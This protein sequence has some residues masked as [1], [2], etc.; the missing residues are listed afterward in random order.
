MLRALE[1]YGLRNWAMVAAD[2]GTKS[3]REAKERFLRYY[4]QRPTHSPITG[5]LPNSPGPSPLSGGLVVVRALWN[6][7]LVTN[8]DLGAHE[9]ILYN[10]P[11]SWEEACLREYIARKH[12]VGDNATVVNLKIC[13]VLKIQDHLFEY[14]VPIAE[15]RK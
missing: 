1:H 5:L 3:E 2:V 4:P 11:P 9:E 7:G 12:Y 14:I 13:F 10:L 8:K 6:F 15:Y